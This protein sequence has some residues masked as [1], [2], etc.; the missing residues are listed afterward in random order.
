MTRS[1]SGQPPDLKKYMDKQLR[2]T[3][4][5][6]ADPHVPTWEKTMNVACYL[7]DPPKG[8]ESYKSLIV[9]LNSCRLAHA[10]RENPIIREDWIKD[11][12]NNASA[13]KGDTVIKSKVQNKVV[14]I[15]EQ[16]I[17]EVLLFG[18]A[19]NDP[20]DYTKEKVMDVL[21]KMSYE[22][23]YPP[24]TKKLLHPYWRFLAHVYLVC[25]SGNKSGID[26]LTIR[27]TSGM[28]SLVE[29]WK[30]NYS[31]CVFDDMMANVKTLNEKYWFKFP[32]FLQ[33]VLETKYPKLQAT[34][35]IYDTKIMNHMVFSMLNQ[36]SRENVKVKYENK[37]P[38][39]KFGVFSEITEEVPAPVNATVVDE[40]DVVII[41]APPGSNEPVE[42]VDF[43]GV[44]SEEDE[45]DDR[46]IDDAEVS[47]NV[48]EREAEVNTGSLTAETQNVEEPVSVNPPHT[49]PVAISTAETEDADE[50]PMADLPPRKRSRKDPRISRE[51]NSETRTTTES[52]LPVTSARPPIHYTPSPL[53][54]AII[55]FIQ[56]E[57]VAMFI[58]AP[59]PGEGSSNSPSDADVVR[60]A[61]LLQAVAREVE[62]AA[63]PI[64]EETHE[65]SS[66]SDSDDLFE[67]NETTILMRRITV[68]EEDKI[69]K[70]AQIASLMEEVVVKNQKIHELET[71]LGALTTIV[72][73]MKQKLEGKFLKEFADPP[74]ETT[75]KERAKEQKEHDEAMDRYIDNP[76]R[77]ANQKLKKKMVV[78]RNV[79]VKRDLQFGD[80]P[81]RYVITTEKDK[82]G[83]RS[84]ILSWSYNDEMEMFIVKR[85]SGAVEY[86]DHSDAFNSWTA[87]DLRELSN[88]TFHN[89]TVNPNC[90]IRWN[91]FNK[92]QQHARVNFKDMKLAQSIVQED[93]EVVDPATGKPYKTVKWPATKQTKTVLLK[94]LPDNSLKDL[95]FWMYDPIIGQAVI[96]C[97]NAEY[98]FLD[99]RD[100]MCFGENDIKLLA[101][102]RIQSDP[103]YEVCAK[104]WTGAVAQIMGF[105]LWSGQ[106]TRVETQLFGPYVGRRLPDLPELQWKQKKQTKKRK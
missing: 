38:L 80:K 100:L 58:P 46:M 4:K 92:L 90:K 19:A 8:F 103:Q 34:V 24:T 32:R 48:G 69:F 96:V 68:L 94:E 3:G 35:K 81:D 73:D 41:Q 63:R 5:T 106:R 91:F 101:K 14:S 57:R 104:S 99:T 78:M 42:N 16:D 11:F 84:S 27:Q 86:Y 22:G 47:E 72:M 76:P 61:E 97:D 54:P 67:E 10:F 93:E 89:Q 49:E 15:S 18:D 33:M 20:V 75:T 70:D 60:A 37:K 98:R 45:T 21:S 7:T 62:A 71:N 64:Q 74:K 12:W 83:N 36:K 31:R 82:H 6:A 51:D 52:T 17:R 39:I 102:T 55:D 13:K 43:T 79:G 2:K 53:S 59:K 77:T 1:R 87:V 28:V 25:I 95:Q 66:S 29:G 50:D 65:A 30:F 40:H 105:K 44:E 23:S 9:G 56:N 88:A 85:K 26:T